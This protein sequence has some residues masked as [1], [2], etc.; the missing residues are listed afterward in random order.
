MKMPQNNL[1]AV[2]TYFN[3]QLADF[4]FDTEI[5]SMQTI[6]LEHY[7]GLDRASIALNPDQLFS[8]SDLLKIINTVKRLR[9]KEPLAY[10]LGEWEFY[11]LTFKV[12]KNTLIP[13]PET[14]ELVELIVTENETVKSIIDIGTGSGCIALSL[15]SELPEATVFAWDVSELALEKVKENAVLNQLEITP[16]C[17]DILASKNNALPQK[18]DVIVSNPPYIPMQEKQ[19]MNDNVLNYEPHLALFIED[20]E[21]LLFYDGISDFAKINLKAGGKLYFEINESYGEATQKLLINKGFNSVEIVKDMNGKDR[22]VK[23]IY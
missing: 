11:G 14:E 23:C 21:P 12:D 16:E 5:A 22:I 18:V 6:V 20:N 2:I 13:R 15:K 8:E 10:I 4:H 17:V 1:Q 3:S 9:K 19:L 7:F